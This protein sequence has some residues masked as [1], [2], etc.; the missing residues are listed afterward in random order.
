MLSWPSAAATAGGQSIQATAARCGSRWREV[1][2]RVAGTRCAQCGFW[3]GGKR[4]PDKRSIPATG[5][6]DPGDASTRSAPMKPLWL[7]AFASDVM[8][9]A[10][11]QQS[12]SALSARQISHRSVTEPTRSVRKDR[13]IGC[14]LSKVAT[15]S[16][17]RPLRS[18]TR[19]SVGMSRIV[20][21]IGATMSHLRAG[22]TPDRVTTSTGL[23]LSSVSAHQMSPWLGVT[24][25]LP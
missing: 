2:R 9:A 24:R 12:A 8:T 10:F 7:P 19:T 16:T 1:A 21:V 14:R 3:R 15:D 18:P 5:C 17:G 23:R 20:L 6:C 4:Q 13:W 22:M 11:G 25:V